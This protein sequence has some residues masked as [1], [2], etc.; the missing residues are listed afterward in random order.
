VWYSLDGGSNETNGCNATSCLVNLTKNWVVGSGGDLWSG[1]ITNDNTTESDDKVV[2]DF[3]V[4]TLGETLYTPHYAWSS[5]I[6][7]DGPY[8]KIA[9][10]IYPDANDT[11]VALGFKAR[12]VL[13]SGTGGTYTVS[14]QS[15]SG[16]EP[17]GIVLTQNTSVDIS[18]NADY[19]I[20]VPGYTAMANTPYWV[21]INQT[22]SDSGNLSQFRY[23]ILPTNIDANYTVKLHGTSSQSWRDINKR[24]SVFYQ[25]DSGEKKGQMIFAGGSTGYGQIYD[26]IYRG[27]L[28]S[29]LTDDFTVGSITYSVYKVGS[30]PGDL[31]FTI[32]DITSS[33]TIFSESIL[34]A[35]EASITFARHTYNLTSPV[36]LTAGHSYRMYFSSPNSNSTD[37]YYTH[38][39]YYHEAQ[40]SY[41]GANSRIQ[42]SFDGGNTW[43]NDWFRTGDDGDLQVYLGSRQYFTSGN[44]TSIM[45][46]L[47]Q[48]RRDTEAGD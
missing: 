42:R 12:P 22:T 8:D 6:Y 36:T 34:T 9:F 40:Y 1:N 39:N 24:G 25:T 35:A 19:T 38:S 10:R 30:P 29:P 43:I 3:D 14:L 13:G 15:D 18:S 11:I 48:I 46:Y 37:F 32:F 27:E 5:W 33:S 45:I 4:S 16:G 47:L 44:L 20:S 17:S 2:L 23:Q 41:D 26:N 28:L 7:D 31:Y 21:V